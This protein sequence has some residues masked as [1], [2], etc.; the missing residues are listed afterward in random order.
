MP[1]SAQRTVGTLSAG[2]GACVAMF[3]LTEEDTW[4][5]I[6][7]HPCVPVP[8]MALAPLPHVSWL[9]NGVMDHLRV[10]LACF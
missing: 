9:G 4:S 3:M 5:E 6:C 1:I 7:V 8:I 2:D 10:S